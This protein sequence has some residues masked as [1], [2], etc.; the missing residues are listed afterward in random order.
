MI[1]TLRGQQY[2]ARAVRR[3]DEP[4]LYLHETGWKPQRTGARRF[5]SQIALTRMTRL[6]PL[7]GARIVA[8]RAEVEAKRVGE[9]IA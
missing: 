8:V 7:Q 2:I 9:P 6:W 1:P 5:P 3:T 4:D